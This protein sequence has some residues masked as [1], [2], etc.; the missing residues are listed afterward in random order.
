MY[1]SHD[2][3]THGSSTISKSAMTGRG[4][5]GDGN[6]RKATGTASYVYEGV[7]VLLFGIG[8]IH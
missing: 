2:R 5:D 3:E 1:V 7:R 4:G 8:R 6:E